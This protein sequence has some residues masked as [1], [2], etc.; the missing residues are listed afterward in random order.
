M[1][2][3]GT[4]VDSRHLKDYPS[5]EFTEAML[6]KY[7][8]IQSARSVCVFLHFILYYFLNVEMQ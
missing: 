8:R 1:G 6:F 2:K 7:Q 5:E 4:I 3:F